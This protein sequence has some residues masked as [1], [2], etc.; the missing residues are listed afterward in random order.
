MQTKEIEEK[1]VANISYVYMTGASR[2]PNHS[3]VKLKQFCKFI[4]V[5]GVSDCF[6]V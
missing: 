3:I 2:A 4:G 5:C 1:L 6:V